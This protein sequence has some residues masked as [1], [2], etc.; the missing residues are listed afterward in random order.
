M[1]EFFGQKHIMLNY[2]NWRFPL[3]PKTVDCSAARI[4][5]AFRL[6]TSKRFYGQSYLDPRL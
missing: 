1:D 4:L 3:A 2:S 6:L 5:T